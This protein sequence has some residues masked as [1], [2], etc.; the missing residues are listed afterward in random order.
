MPLATLVATAPP[1]VTAV[2]PVVVTLLLGL[3]SLELHPAFRERPVETAGSDAVDDRIGVQA[4]GQ[5]RAKE[6]LAPVP[7]AAIGRGANRERQPYDTE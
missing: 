1:V 5:R 7:R 3:R 6:R 4:G 2:A